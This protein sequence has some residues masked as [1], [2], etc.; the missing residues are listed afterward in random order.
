MVILLMG[1]TGSGKTTVGVALAEALGWRFVDADDLHP[2]ANVAK[3]RA[4]VP[5][6]D[7]DRAPWLAALHAAI[8]DW[9]NS[10]SDIVLACSA[11][12]QA[13]R[14]QLMFS[15]NARLVYLRGGRELIAQRLSQRHGHYMDP[16]LLPSQ[17]AALEEPANAIVVDVDTTVPEIVTRVR[18]AL[19]V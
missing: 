17:F 15:P 12:K 7:D 6:N 5:L 13:Y 11:L 4:G 18:T 3:M 14:E 19:G 10:K 1:V 2:P 16:D 8:A 9:L